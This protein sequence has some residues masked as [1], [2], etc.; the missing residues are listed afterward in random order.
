[1]CEGV[2]GWWW[3]LASA[4]CLLWLLSLDS[5]LDGEERNHRLLSDN[6][7]LLI[8]NVKL[9]VSLSPAS[10]LL[11]QAGCPVMQ[12]TTLHYHWLTEVSRWMPHVAAT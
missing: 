7:S 9:N 6:C 1:M 12:A 8:Y 4:W 10:A 3:C 5:R 2:A 11:L